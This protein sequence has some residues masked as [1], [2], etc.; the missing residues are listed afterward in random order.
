[1]SI[2]QGFKRTQKNLV[3]G[4]KTNLARVQRS[5]RQ[6]PSFEDFYQHPSSNFHSSRRSDHRSGERTLCNGPDKERASFERRIDPH[7]KDEVEIIGDQD[8]PDDIQ[9][10]TQRERGELLAV[11][12]GS[13]CDRN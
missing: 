6:S 9:A 2:G 4:E 1:M 7:D 5:Q 8:D 13:D 12:L 11:S 3:L 10:D